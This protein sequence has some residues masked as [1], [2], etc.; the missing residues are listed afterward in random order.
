MEIR[1]LVNHSDIFDVVDTE[2]ISQDN[3][4]Q[5]EK[6]LLGLFFITLSL[7]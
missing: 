6:I 4:N 5:Y 1:N 2:V 7:R 3:V